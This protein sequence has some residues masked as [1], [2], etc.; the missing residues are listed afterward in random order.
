MHTPPP[1][2]GNY[3]QSFVHTA[4]P[5][6]HMSS[7]Y[8]AQH[9]PF[10]QSRR[11][12]TY[13]RAQG[14]STYPTNNCHSACMRCCQPLL[15]LP[16]HWP[17]CCHAPTRRESCCDSHACCYHCT[18]HP[19][20]AWH[21]HSIYQS[22]CSHP[23]LYSLPLGFQPLYISRA[24][25]FTPGMWTVPPQSGAR[26]NSNLPGASPIPSMGGYGRQ[27]PFPSHLN[28]FTEQDVRHRPSSASWETGALSTTSWG[29]GDSTLPHVPPTSIPPFPVNGEGQDDRNYFVPPAPTKHEVRFDTPPSPFIPPVATPPSFHGSTMHPIGMPSPV[30]P[31]FTSRNQREESKE[32]RD[33]QDLGHAGDSSDA[34]ARPQ[35]AGPIPNNVGSPHPHPSPSPSLWLPLNPNTLEES[36]AL[37]DGAGLAIASTASDL[38]HTAEQSDTSNG[39]PPRRWGPFRLPTRSEPSTTE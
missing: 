28:H 32:R 29:K 36:T 30:I 10:H 2:N 16:C 9:A 38:N 19:L 22:R 8:N 39:T 1:Q 31:Q 26:W 27:A 25:P 35:A 37:T 33:D 23:H 34:V 18:P 15:D 7:S 5:R 17:H 21:Y 3:A 12:E 20:N 13:E 6:Q 14:Q 24:S 11:Q 4:L